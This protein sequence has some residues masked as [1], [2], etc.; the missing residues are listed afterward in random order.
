VSPPN[1]GGS[2]P[3][4]PAVEFDHAKADEA[5]RQL[6]ALIPVLSQHQKDRQANGQS[7]RQSWKGH[8]AVEFDGELKRMWL[9]HGDL[10]TRAR[11]LRTRIA[12]AAA[13]AQAQQRWRDQQN[14][15]WQVRQPQPAGHR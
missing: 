14:H 2:G 13:A 7:L 12:D 1:P 10:V 4:Y 6:D 3:P 11:A 9:D 8:Y 15:D 5:I